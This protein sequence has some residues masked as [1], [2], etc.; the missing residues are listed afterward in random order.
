[1]ADDFDPL[2]NTVNKSF[3]DS[4]SKHDSF[5][6]QKEKNYHILYLINRPTRTG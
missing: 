5:F 4:N 6:V 2:K 3:Q 1:M